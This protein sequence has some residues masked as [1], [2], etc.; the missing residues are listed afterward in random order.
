M[1]IHPLRQHGLGFVYPNNLQSKNNES[2]I[3]RNRDY[4]TRKPKISGMC[5]DKY[6]SPMPQVGTLESHNPSRS[7]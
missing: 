2:K 1:G 5:Y 3:F 6:A 4:Y 7:N